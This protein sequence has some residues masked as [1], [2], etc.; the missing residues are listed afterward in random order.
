M[1]P[2]EYQLQNKELVKQWI[3]ALRSGNYQQTQYKL[4]ERG[5]NSDSYCCLGVLCEIA[6]PL[7]SLEEGNSLE[8]YL[9][10]GGYPP[11]EVLKLLGQNF[12][13]EDD[14]YKCISV[15]IEDKGFIAVHSLNDAYNKSFAEIADLLEQ[16]HL[17]DG[18]DKQ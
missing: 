5:L 6:K 16:T 18:E 11:E 3:E 10:V 1:L 9:N 7:L 4:R 8:K 2:V 12:D 14:N 13:I 17:K 15:Q